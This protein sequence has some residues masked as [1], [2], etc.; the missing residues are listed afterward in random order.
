MRR[1]TLQ[2]L[3]IF[4][5]SIIIGLGVNFSLVRMY[6]KGEF[7]H[8]FF[9]ARKYSGISFISLAEAEALFASQAALFIDSREKEAFLS[10]HIIGALNIPYEEENKERALKEYGLSP[11]NTVV[12]YCDGSE[13]QSSIHLAEFLHHKGLRDIRVFFGGW[14]EWLEAGLPVE[15]E[16]VRQ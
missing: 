10:G 1:I 12:V 13:C 16:S 4:M 15:G 9:P 14:K 2:I 11:G 6:F 7:I 8:G 3:A 5:L